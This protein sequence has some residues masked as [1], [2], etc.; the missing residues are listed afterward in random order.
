MTRNIPE[1][2]GLGNIVI[3][4]VDDVHKSDMVT[5]QLMTVLLVNL[6]RVPI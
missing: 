5:W 3:S 2:C 1:P 6:N 4:T